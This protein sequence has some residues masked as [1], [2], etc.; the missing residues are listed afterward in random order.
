MFPQTKFQVACFKDKAN[1]K[2][3]H[4][5]RDTQTDGRADR[6]R[7]ISG[8]THLSLARELKKKTKKQKNQ[9]RPGPDSTRLSTELEHSNISSPMTWGSHHPLRFSV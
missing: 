2:V 5:Q 9:A 7:R 8:Q 3:Y 1:V 4:E 6:G